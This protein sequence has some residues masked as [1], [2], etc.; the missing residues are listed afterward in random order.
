MPEG[1]TIFRAAANLGRALEGRTILRFETGYAQLARIDD[2]TPLPGRL[3][4]RVWS[5]GK[6]LL[7]RFSGGLTLR[8]H[9]RMSGSWHLYR[10][11]QAWQ[12]PRSDLRLLLE[13]GPASADAATGC[14][15]D[16]VG[17]LAVAF[18]VP[19]AE[20]LD[21]HALA[22]SP[23]LRRLGPDLLAD[24]FDPA[25]ARARVRAAPDRPVGE[26]LL[27]QSVAAGAGNVYRSE[28]LFLSGLA[29]A[30][31]VSAVAD[32]EL[33]AMFA[34]TRK[35]MRANVSTTGPGATGNIVTYTGL[36]RTTNRS[37]PGER[38]WVYGRGGKPCRRC[39]TP[40]AYVK[41]G[42][43]ARGLYFCPRCQRATATCLG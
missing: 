25:L 14:A 41:T 32:E 35:L 15:S 9:M 43:D 16:P 18:S 23:E 33:E 22:R 19:V 11:G 6:H 4:E 31:L 12:R 8:T 17:F 1:D 13:V 42:A 29:P 5:E 28:V 39:G 2:D 24:D 10:P 36:R 21:D 20:L 38:L 34:L 26:I 40:I 27:D 30:R 7:M 37:D 3:V